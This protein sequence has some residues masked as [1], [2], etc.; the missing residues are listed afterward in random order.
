M[1]EAII[2]I[3][4][5]FGRA[6]SEVLGL[7]VFG[8]AARGM[9]RQDSDLDIAV[10]AAADLIPSDTTGATLAYVLELEERLN[11]QSMW[12]RSTQLRRCSAIRY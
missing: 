12:S 5:E 11:R 9:A 1:D 4:Q 6:H 10:L 7:Y 8:S 3:L 2:A